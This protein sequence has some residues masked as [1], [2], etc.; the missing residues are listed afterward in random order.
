MFLLGDANHYL[1]YEL[2]PI[3]KTED[4]DSTNQNRYVSYLEAIIKTLNNAPITILMCNKLDGVEQYLEDGYINN[5]GIVNLIKNGCSIT[6][7]QLT[8]EQDELG[9]KLG[10][11][12]WTNGVKT[13]Y[14]STNTDDMQSLFEYEIFSITL[15]PGFYDGTDP[16]TMGAMFWLNRLPITLY[17]ENTAQTNYGSLIYTFPYIENPYLYVIMMSLIYV[18]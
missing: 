17:K 3:A 7:G 5:T 16:N 12:T 1:L 11:N 14:R 18:M 9:F 10:I 13:Y 6:V 2:G 8:N 4:D 15:H